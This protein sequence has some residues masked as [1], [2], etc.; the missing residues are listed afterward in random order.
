MSQL[1]SKSKYLNGLQCPRYLWIL[2]HEPE[3]I[4]ETDTVTQY[5]FAQGHVV[6]E[7]AKQLFPDGVDIPT[8][9]FMDN[10][11]E[12]QRLLE[13]HKPLFEAGILV[14]GLYSRVDVLNP[15]GEDRWDLIEV[16][17]STGVKDVHIHDASFQR[18][19]CEKSGLKIGKCY[20]MHINNQYT[21]EGEIDPEKFFI[22][23]DISVE[24]EKV[25]NCIQ[26]RVDNMF[27]IISANRC[28]E[29]SIGKHCSDPYDCPLT[30]CWKALPEGHVFN[31]Y[32]GGNK[33]VELYEQG[34]L[35]ISNIPDDYRL[36]GA[37]LIQKECEV[38][39]L[40]HVNKAGIS[41]FLAILQYPFYYLDFETINP[42]VPLFNGT[43]PYQAIPFQFSLHAVKEDGSEPEHFSFL[44]SGADDP[45]P[46]FL[47]ELK[48]VLGN[49][50]SIIVYNQGFEEG[51]LKELARAF[52]DYDSWV[53][54][55]RS[56]FVDLL[57]P[58]RSF[59][60]YHPL[61]KGS[62]SLKSVLPVL[63]GKSY[64]GMDIADGE[65][66]SIK[67]QTVTYGNVSEEERN[68]VRA[69]LEKYCSLD[70]EG[71]ILI[72]D[73]LRELGR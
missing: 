1:L 3:R 5:I 67:F 41:D 28:P 46:R 16:K 7:L 2:F 33:S 12:T 23:Q 14:E 68:K 6:G 35:V 70:T 63:T 10:I 65:S 9:G 64:E 42:A 56:R 45:R 29:V 24:V 19:C 43:R 20:L 26:D 59:Y 54:Q 58:F 49:A 22:I 17:S 52:P 72:V 11:K 25:A 18:L 71:M 62:A 73:N 37:Q 39:G 48:K 40:A 31:L 4:P 38:T 15:N 32:R 55:I 13:Q 36:T 44:A 66:A 50:G 47:M 30:E 27:D 53:N 60:Y 57:A 21:K 51:I 69:E 34:I 61:Q 8:D